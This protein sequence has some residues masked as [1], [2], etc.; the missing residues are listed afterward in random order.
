M[1][2]FAYNEWFSIGQFIDKAMYQGLY[3]NLIKKTIVAISKGDK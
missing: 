1:K 2:L 3:K